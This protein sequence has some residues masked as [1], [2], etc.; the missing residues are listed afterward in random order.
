MGMVCSDAKDTN[1]IT[2]WKFCYI[3]TENGRFI[4]DLP[5]KDGDFP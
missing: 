5:I 1:E 2:L 3:A 4:F